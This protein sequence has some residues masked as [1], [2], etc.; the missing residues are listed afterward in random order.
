M[1]GTPLTVDMAM[2]DPGQ[3]AS[4]DDIERLE[5]LYGLDKPWYEAYFVWLGNVIARR[6]WP[7]DSQE[8]RARAAPDRERLPA[9]LML[10]VTS[11]VLTYVLSIPIGLWSTAKS[12]TTASAR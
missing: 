8:Q 4:P 5:R 2:M 1:P 3:M 6:L 9:T 11:L 7:L 12:G 10:S